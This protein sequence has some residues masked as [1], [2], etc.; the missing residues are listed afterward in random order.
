ML[1]RQAEYVAR[2]SIERRSS[3]AWNLWGCHARSVMNYDDDG[4][5][6]CFCND[7][8]SACLDLLSHA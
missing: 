7:T 5:A 3:T 2:R 4:D 8:R 1:L 6:V